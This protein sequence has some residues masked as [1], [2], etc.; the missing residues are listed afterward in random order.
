MSHGAAQRGWMANAGMS[1]VRQRHD[2][3]GFDERADGNVIIALGRIGQLFH[4]RSPHVFIPVGGQH[5]RLVRA[6]PQAS[7]L[8]CSHV[9]A[10]ETRE[11]WAAAY[12][13]EGDGVRNDCLID[14]KH[15]DIARI[16]ERRAQFSEVVHTK[17]PESCLLDEVEH[18]LYPPGAVTASQRAVGAQ[19][20]RSG[21]RRLSTQT[22]CSAP[23]PRS[24]S[25]TRHNLDVLLGLDRLCTEGDVLLEKRLPGGRARERGRG[26]VCGARAARMRGRHPCSWLRRD[27]H[28]PGRARRPSLPA[29]APAPLP[30]R[31]RPVW[32]PEAPAAA[33]RPR[34]ALPRPWPRRALPRCRAAA[35]LVPRARRSVA[36]T[37]ECT[38]S[39]CPPGP[40][41]CRHGP[42]R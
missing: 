30:R 31:P 26:A 36:R 24:A 4:G 42:W 3:E 19:A 27:A 7:T 38:G 40:G 21:P 39:R 18:F 34:P 14:R 17:L 12:R 32:R 1:A 25:H 37:C 13:H 5:L 20:S 22:P 9:H 16:V 6:H 35:L 10:C 8:A 29:F 41:G 2:L 33:A 28:A 23:R 15:F 11:R